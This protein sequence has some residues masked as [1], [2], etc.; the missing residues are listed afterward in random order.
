M[1]TLFSQ[2]AQNANLLPNQRAVLKLVEGTMLAIILAGLTAVAPILSNGNGSVDWHQ[3]A[4]VG[5]A[6]MLLAVFNTLK[7]G[8]TAASDPPLATAAPSPLVP[9]TGLD[10]PMP[11]VSNAPASPSYVTAPLII[12]PDKPFNSKADTYP[13]DPPPMLSNTL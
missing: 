10:A 12:P 11:P 2:A 8:M 3:V 13:I 9:F 7:K 1:S 6:A 5:I 4:T